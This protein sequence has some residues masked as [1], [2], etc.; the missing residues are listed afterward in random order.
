MCLLMVGAAATRP[1]NPTAA[2]LDKEIAALIVQ[3]DSPD[4]KIRERAMERLINFGPRVIKPLKEA[5]A[6]DV[7]P[8]FASRA[9]SVLDEIAR[10]WR[11]VNDNG[12]NVVG[13]FQ[14]TL[15]GKPADFEAGKPISLSLFFRCVASGGGRMWEPRSID[16]QLGDGPAFTAPEAEGKLI[17]RKMGE[18]KLPQQ[19]RALI[20]SS[21]EP[22]AI[23]FNVGGSVHTSL[24]IDREIELGPGEYEIQFIYYAF[25]RGLLKDSLEDLESNVLRIRIAR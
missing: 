12:G 20:C 8:E 19:A 10:Q 1:V 4:A 21:G 24:W 17:V 6:L 15:H 11:Y 22:H 23:D 16:V 9:K 5:M 18:A 14:A 3:L 2:G 7:T 13:G 25:T